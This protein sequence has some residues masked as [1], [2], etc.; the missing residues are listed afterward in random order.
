MAN[1]IGVLADIGEVY[2]EGEKEICN[3]SFKYSSSLKVYL[4]DI[5]TKELVPSLN[6]KPEDFIICRNTK[7]KADL[8]SPYLYPIEK[9]KT[10]CLKRDN[11]DD[12]TFKKTISTFLSYF[13]D[14]EIKNNNILSLLKNIDDAFLNKCEEE[15]KSINI[16][17]KYENYLA[18]SYQGNPISKLF[19]QVFEIF[20]NKSELSTSYGY[21]IL[22]NTEGVGADASLLF[23]SLNEMVEDSTK[24]IESFVIK[25]KIRRLP[26]NEVSAKKIRL[27]FEKLENISCDIDGSEIKMAILPTVLSKDKKTLKKIVRIIENEAEQAKATPEK[28]R[29]IE[30]KVMRFLN[31]TAE[32]ESKDEIKNSVLNTLLFYTKN[33]SKMVLSLTIDDVLPSYV[34]FV[35][36]VMGKY[37]IHSFNGEGI[38]NENDS[39][40]NRALFLSFL[41]KN[42]R[43][44]KSK[45]SEQGNGNQKIQNQLKTMEFLFSRKKIKTEEIIRLYAESIVNNANEPFLWTEYFRDSYRGKYNFPIPTIERLHSFFNEI[46]ILTE[47]INIERKKMKDFTEEELLDIVQSCGLLKQS[48]MHQAA[49]LLGVLSQAIFRWQQYVRGDYFSQTAFSKF[50]NRNKQITKDKLLEINQECS[51]TIGKLL[52]QSEGNKRVNVASSVLLP[53]LAEAAVYN[54]VVKKEELTLAFSLG[55]RDFEAYWKLQN[56]KKGAEKEIEEEA[57]PQPNINV[58]DNAHKQEQSLFNF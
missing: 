50:I 7:K 16:D 10:N 41:F 57:L 49:Y 55:G 27:G 12:F 13:N 23:C 52:S 54:K 19:P 21:D 20:L 48:S 17:K 35:S 38:W 2:L 31:S 33:K 47:T 25:E 42:N 36:G 30:N 1:L 22:T 3:E 53:I 56:Q 4:F 14:D 43:V 18:F 8:S 45:G 37:N 44:K 6:I 26:L 11:K 34:S 5:E 58:V 32:G 40:E 28:V 39:L 29:K 15:I 24:A 51:K 9:I 46:D